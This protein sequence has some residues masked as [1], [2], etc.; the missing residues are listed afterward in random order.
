MKVNI[1]II[2]AMIILKENKQKRKTLN[3]GV[4]ISYSQ[5]EKSLIMTTFIINYFQSVRSLESL[6]K[7]VV[8][9]M[10]NKRN[11]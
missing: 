6:S 5:W 7:K 10:L 2:L 3:L 11:I 1:E 8:I 9:S 4:D